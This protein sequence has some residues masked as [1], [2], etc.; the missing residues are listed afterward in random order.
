MYFGVCLNVISVS[1]LVYLEQ[2]VIPFSYPISLFRTL[3]RPRWRSWGVETISCLLFFH[4]LSPRPLFYLTPSFKS[5]SI[6]SVSPGPKSFCNKFYKVEAWNRCYSIWLESKYG[7][8]YYWDM[9][10]SLNTALEIKDSTDGVL[11]FLQCYASPTVPF[12]MWFLCCLQKQ[13]V[14]MKHVW[15]KEITYGKSCHGVWS[16]VIPR[17]ELRAIN[18]LLTSYVPWDWY[19]PSFSTQFR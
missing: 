10:Q 8:C 15:K 3:S 14:F 6:I 12:S 7:F 19:F 18:T 17:L 5:V 11:H 1:S 13:V 9:K 2:F 4:F 16:Q